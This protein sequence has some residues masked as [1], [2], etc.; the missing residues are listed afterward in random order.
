MLIRVLLNPKNKKLELVQGMNLFQT[1]S[2][3]DGNSSKV[4]VESCDTDNIISK[5]K[6]N[7]LNL[8]RIRP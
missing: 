4:I 3:V 6:V 1:R 8:N 2:K 7:K 5:E